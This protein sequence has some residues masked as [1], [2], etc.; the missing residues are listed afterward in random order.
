M[1]PYDDLQV[2]D[3][4]QSI[5]G[6]L[7][8]QLLGALGATVTKVEP[9]EGDAF[10]E[11]LDGAMFAAYNLGG[12]RS[13]C[14][15]LKTDDGKRIA[16][17][18]AAEADVVIE[19]FRPGVTERFG[20]DYESVRE[21]NSDVIYVS[22]SGFGQD[23][24]YSDRPA[25]DP[26]LQA[27][28]G[29]MSMTGYPDRPP[30]RVG[31]ST[32][33]CSTGMCAAFLVASALRNRERTGD[34]EYVDVSLFDTAIQWMAYW[35]AYS[36]GGNE[37]PERGGQGL[38][39]IAPNEVIEAADGDPLY[40]SAIN[41]QFFERLCETIDR[42]DLIEDDRFAD[43]DS[44]WAHRNALRDELE[45]AAQRFDREKLVEELV[46]A[47]VPAGPVRSVDELVADPHVSHREMLVDSYN[48]R[49]E[50]PVKTANLPFRTDSETPDLDA[51]PPA[52]GEHTRSVL[53]ERGYADA[54][55]DSL[56]ER[57]AVDEP[58]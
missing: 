55:I 45:A 33:D 56:V 44:R 16:R 20:L 19:S 10:R 46:D 50:T 2:V 12:K 1:E 26:I 35:I 39:G 23:G 29:L 25:Y 47:G 21:S 30:V 57:G 3:F 15:D 31:A 36:T 8:T 4:T 14:L 43:N 28:S 37:P 40:V 24:P 18:L 9:P 52:L 34:G 49:T 51:D 11:L 5:A 42:P 27:M 41:D 38:A 7:A 54:E 58:E 6:P 13:V 48:T 53:A 22:L 17:E 32:I